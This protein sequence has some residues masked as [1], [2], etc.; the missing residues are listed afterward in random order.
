MRLVEQV[1]DGFRDARLGVGFQI[2]RARPPYRVAT[3]RELIRR[4]KVTV[5]AVCETDHHR[6]AERARL[7][8]R[9]ARAPESLTRNR[10]DTEISDSKCLEPEFPSRW[11]IGQKNRFTR[12]VFLPVARGPVA[13]LRCEVF[14][15]FGHLLPR[16][17]ANVESHPSA[18]GRERRPIAI[19]HSR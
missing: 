2:T 19:F 15:R 18:R 16:R 14:P 8:D 6:K 7:F 5:V 3:Q 9:Q 11:P 13:D 17:Q 4:R 1:E 12:I 10:G